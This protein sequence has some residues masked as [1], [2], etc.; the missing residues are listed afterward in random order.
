MR[1]SERARPRARGWLAVPAALALTLAACGGD[2][3]ADGDVVELRYAFWGSDE[4]AQMT[5]DMIDKFEAENPDIRIQPDY[6]DF[7]AYFD[8]LATSVAAGDAPDVITM[9]GAYPSEYAGRGALLDL[10]E[11]DDL[12]RTD[13]IDEAILDNGVI[14]G[15]QYAIPTGVNTYAMVANPAVFDRAGVEMPDDSTWTWD[16]YARICAELGQGLGEDGFGSQ[17]PTNHNTLK[18]FA[19]QHGEQLY[20]ED[21]ELG[22]SAETV[23]E[24]WELALELRDSG[25]TPPAARTAELAS[26]EAPEQTLIG[27]NSAGL[28]LIW[29]N[30]LEALNSASGE[31][32]VLLKPPGE[33]EGEPGLWL[34]PSMFYTIAAQSEHP[35]EAARFV[36]FM[37][38]ESAAAESFLTD[39]GLPVNATVR[40]SIT[41]LLTPTQQTEAEFLTRVEQE[42]G[43]AAPAP[44]VGSTETS[45]IVSRLNSEVLF[46]RLTPREAAER[47]V[48]EVEAALAS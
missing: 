1:I 5:Q 22:I 20:T 10:A 30:V 48:T 45:L 40:E 34:G 23:E 44:P 2:D 28:S 14:E 47:F 3:E 38:N 16:D 27:T 39:R 19:R 37:L 11:V 17:D 13:D 42:G 43:S 6:A 21:G 7:G 35:E 31:E 4:R 29:S 41:E 36:D 24:W 26:Q 46:D 33:S 32:L 9:G 15:A 18:L 12:I 8:K 25:G